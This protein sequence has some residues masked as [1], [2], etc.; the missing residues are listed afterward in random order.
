[1]KKPPRIGSA[2]GSFDVSVSREPAPGFAA[3]PGNDTSS[4]SYRWSNVS[5]RFVYQATTTRP[6]VGSAAI[7]GKKLTPPPEITVGVDHVAPRSSEYVS[8]TT[9]SSQIVSSGRAVHSS[10]V[11]NILDF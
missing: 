7:V 11:T 4:T 6:L 10:Q 5:N 8:F 3:A 1:M 9:G 2:S